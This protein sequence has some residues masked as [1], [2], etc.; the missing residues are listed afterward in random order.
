MSSPL[1]NKETTTV[2]TSDMIARVQLVL[3]IFTPVPAKERPISMMTGPTTTGGKSREMNPTPRRRTRVL[4]I[5]YTAPTATRPHNVPGSPKSS[6]ALM[7]G[8]MK[9]KLLPR[10]TGTLPLVT[11]WKIK[12]PT[13]AVNNATEGSNP[14]RSG[15][16]TVAPKATKRN[17]APTIVF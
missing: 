17:C 6:V 4:I 5:P 16:S 13:P 8:A 14:T 2:V 7:I 3:A 15:T 12:V 10:K 9:A 11:A 1:P